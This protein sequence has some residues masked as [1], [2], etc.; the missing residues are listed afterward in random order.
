M[1]APLKELPLPGVLRY[2]L[3]TAAGR[4]LPIVRDG[5]SARAGDIIA[6]RPARA[7]PR[8]ARPAQRWPSAWR[9]D[10][11]VADLLRAAAPGRIELAPDAVALHVDGG[12]EPPPP[13]TARSFVERVCEAGIVGMGGA[14][15]P[16]HLKLRDAIAHGVATV[17]VNAVECEPGVAVDRALLQGHAEDVLR[18]MQALTQALGGAQAVLALDAP[19]QLD[20]AIKTQVVPGPYPAGWEPLLVR[21]LL[22]LEVPQGGYPVSVGVVVFN[23]AT[24]FAMGRAWHNAEPLTRRV[25]AISD[26]PRWTRIGH[27]VAELPPVPGEKPGEKMLG[28]PVTGWPAAP[29]DAVSRTTRAV[30]LRTGAAATPCI[31]CGWCANAC[32]VGLLPQELLRAATAER[33][34]ETERLAVDDCIECGACDMACPSR[35]PLLAHFRFAKAARSAAARRE[36]EAARAKEHVEQRRIRVSRR[37]AEATTRRAE[38]LRNPR[39]WGAAASSRPAQRKEATEGEG[40]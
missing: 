13:L 30:T 22:G 38:R 28:G 4:Y 10:E 3:A 6:V 21:R 20:A 18:G 40:H 32:P 25:V 12:D 24:V 8:A 16:T 26:E 39:D 35:L 33:W 27:P 15:Y 2:A 19:L 7:A 29:D 5:A 36:Q 37:A 1:A 17:I 34:A 11:A 31:R 9:P 23:V 14:G